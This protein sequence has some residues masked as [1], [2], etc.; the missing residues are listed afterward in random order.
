MTPTALAW[1]S[2]L[3][4]EKPVRDEYNSVV[5][6]RAHEK[7]KGSGGLSVGRG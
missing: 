2:V 5:T 1:A 6:D 4:L 7:G 3:S